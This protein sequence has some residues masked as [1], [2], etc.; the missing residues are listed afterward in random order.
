MTTRIICIGDDFMSRVR[1]MFVYFFVLLGEAALIFMAKEPTTCTGTIYIMKITGGD[2]LDKVEKVRQLSHITVGVICLLACIGLL[3]MAIDLI[4]G[5]SKGLLKF[6]YLFMAV[7]N[8]IQVVA[9]I[10]IF[11]STDLIRSSTQKANCL[12]YFISQV[13]LLIVMC[14]YILRELGLMRFLDKLSTVLLLA[15]VG[16]IVSNGLLLRGSNIKES[17]IYGCITALPTLAIFVFEAFVLEASIR[18]NR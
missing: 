14:L 9:C 17:L 10:Y 4:G 12:V 1:A 7:Y 5:K 13:I 3:L 6:A 18:R 16:Q 2:Q 8:L 15:I 11:A